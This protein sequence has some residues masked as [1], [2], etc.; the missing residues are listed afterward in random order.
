MR[1]FWEKPIIGIYKITHRESGKCYIGQSVDVFKRWQGHS[2]L[3]VKKKSAIQHAFVAH[4]IDQFSFEVLEE[5]DR[6]MLND[7][8]VH[9]IAYFGSFGEGG[10]NLTSGGGQGVTVSDDTKKEMSEKRKGKN[11]GKQKQ[12]QCPHCGEVGGNVMKR[13]HFDNC[14]TLGIKHTLK[15]NSR[16]QSEETKRKLSEAMKGKKRAIV[17]CPHCHKEGPI[18]VL[19]RYH[20]ENCKIYKELGVPKLGE[21]TVP[22]TR[23]LN[24]LLFPK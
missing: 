16:P 9:W 17:T 18:N 21:E 2:N 1:K 6:E 20:F 5:R 13:F 22:D 23:G 15:R 8:E 12:I 4:G 11:K 3:A 14:K 19:K 10:Y 7:R 24:A